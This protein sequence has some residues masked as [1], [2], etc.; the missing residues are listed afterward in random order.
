MHVGGA[1][2]ESTEKQVAQ[3]LKGCMS[4]AKTFEL[5]PAGTKIMDS[6]LTGTMDSGSLCLQSFAYP[7]HQAQGQLQTCVCVC[8]LDYQSI[9]DLL[10]IIEPLI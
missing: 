10:R 3:C 8:I 1:R 2:N 5:Y 9:T 6:G 4:D 7:Q